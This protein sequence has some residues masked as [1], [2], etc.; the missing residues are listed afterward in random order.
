MKRIEGR[1]ISIKRSQRPTFDFSSS[2]LSVSPSLPLHSSQVSLFVNMMRDG[3]R[4]DFGLNLES[5]FLSIQDLILNP[6]ST[7]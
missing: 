4:K 6:N 1:K 2:L 5:L 7:H 3:D